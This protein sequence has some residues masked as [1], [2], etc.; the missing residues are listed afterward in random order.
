MLCCDHVKS[1]GKILRPLHLMRLKLDSE[2]LRRALRLFPGK[3]DCGVGW[4]PERR[5]A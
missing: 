4:I 3:D 5:R 1:S 2:R